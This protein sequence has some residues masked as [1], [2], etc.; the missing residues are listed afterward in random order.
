M[1]KKQ[2]Y[3]EQEDAADR[4]G[5]RAILE[6]AKKT[7][8]K[9]RHPA[10]TGKQDPDPV[11]DQSNR[12]RLH[13]SARGIG[14]DR[15][16]IR[17]QLLFT[18]SAYDA[19]QKAAERAG[20]SLNAYISD[21]LDNAALYALKISHMDSETKSRRVQIVLSESQASALAKQAQRAALSENAYIAALMLAEE[22][23]NG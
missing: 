9:P 14:K 5:I 17:K 21:R 23:H 3:T 22:N 18:P 10:P 7:A 8:P 19:V 20:L 15:K 16:T 6:T 13:I 1:K 2:F 4:S 11:S 12:P